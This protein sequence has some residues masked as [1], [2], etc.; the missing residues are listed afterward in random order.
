M[1]KFSTL[2]LLT[3]LLVL[4]AC[5]SR[6]LPS[7]AI[8]FHE[9]IDDLKAKE[10]NTLY[11]EDISTGVPGT[12]QYILQM[13]KYTYTTPQAD[14]INYKFYR[15]KLAYAFI[16]FKDRSYDELLENFNKSHK[17]QKIHDN[18]FLIDST[19]VRVGLEHHKN[20]SLLYLNDQDKE[21]TDV[22]NNDYFH[23][24]KTDTT[25]RSNDLFVT[26]LILAL[27]GKGRYSSMTD[28]YFYYEGIYFNR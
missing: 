19:C 21:I 8:S 25:Y 10:T 24:I 4:Y 7:P 17:A 27:Y 13:K 18:I 6:P 14:T 5:G 16:T 11:N 2:A 12:M 9:S 15:G 20:A 26:Q 22:I 28:T 1:N 3:F 23:K